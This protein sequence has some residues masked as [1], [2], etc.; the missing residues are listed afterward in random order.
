MKPDD[1]KIGHE[2]ARTLGNMGIC[3]MGGN[4]LAEA[5]A[6]FDRARQV[7][8]VIGDANPTLIMIPAASAWIDAMA[9]EALIALK[10]DPEAL[11]ALERARA[12][13]ATQIKANP[14]VTRNREQLIRIHGASQTFTAGQ[15]GW[16]MRW[17]HLS[18]HRRSR[19]VWPTA[20]RKTAAASSTLLQLT[21]TLA[22]C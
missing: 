7:L 17:L 1:P 21:P 16:R 13:R 6:A 11:A 9:A 2:L 20:T 19:R 8:K 14:S 18:K 3:L 22:T 10:R 15:D 5:L 12:S 4:R